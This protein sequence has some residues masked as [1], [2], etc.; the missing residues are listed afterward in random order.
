M[1]IRYC[2]DRY[3]NPKPIKT[4]TSSFANKRSRELKYPFLVTTHSSHQTI[5][6]HPDRLKMEPR[7]RVH[8]SHTTLMIHTSLW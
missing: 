2:S 3:Q 6:T 4:H 5:T 8:P 1:T 7:Q